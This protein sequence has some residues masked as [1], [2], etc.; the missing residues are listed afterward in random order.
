MAERRFPV[1]LAR[2]TEDANP[3]IRSTDYAME[4][5]LDGVRITA[6]L[7]NGKLSAFSRNGTRALLP[8]LIRE[9]LK[10]LVQPHPGTWH[11]DG[12]LCDDQ[13]HIFDVVEN[14]TGQIDTLPWSERRAVLDRLFYPHQTTS[15]S[16]LHVRATNWLVRPSDKSCWMEMLLDE[17][18]EGAIFKNIN[19]KYSGKRTG[20]WLKFKFTKTIDVVVVKLQRGGKEE[21]MDI[22]LYE[23]EKMWLVGGCRILPQFLGHVKVGDVVEVRYLYA[24]D[25]RKLYQPSMIRIRDD[26]S[27]TECDFSQMKFTNRATL[28]PLGG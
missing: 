25:N 10:S 24:T 26:K 22:G 6:R 12:E 8:A 9:E 11:F 4:Q 13:Y 28:T 2:E 3:Y 21:S 18:A 27:P 17:G 14:P 19:S 1:T 23:G 16:S 7:E 15:A 20:L 5:K